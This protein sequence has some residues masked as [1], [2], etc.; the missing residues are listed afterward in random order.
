MESAV[1]GWGG[2]CCLGVGWRVLFGGGVESAV[3]GWGGECCLGVG[4]RVLFGGGVESAVWGWGVGSR[5]LFGG[6]TMRYAS[7]Q[8][9]AYSQYFWGR[10]SGGEATTTAPCLVVQPVFIV[11]CRMPYNGMQLQIK[12]LD[13]TH[14]TQ[15][16][17]VQIVV[18]GA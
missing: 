4:W 1:W 3:W 9:D 15:A 5:V 8:V 12:T 11:W 2:E 14:C 6:H 18:G 13:H 16:C 10:V 7:T 17:S